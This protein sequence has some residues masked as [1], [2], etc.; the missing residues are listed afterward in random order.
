MKPLFI[1]C[2]AVLLIAVIPGT[3][4]LNADELQPVTSED[5][6]L[7]RPVEFVTDVYPI[8][9]ANCIACHNKSVAEGDLIL[10]NVEAILK[11]G[12]TG[13]AAVPEK[14][15]ES[16]LFLL[17]RRGEEP[18][19]PPLPND[20]QAK[21]LEPKQLGIL[22]QWILEGA[23]K[24]TVAAKTMNWQPISSKLQ[25]VYALDMD[26]A[27][28]FIAAG[29][30]NRVSIYDLARRDHVQ[31]LVDREILLPGMPDGGAGAVAGVTHLDYVHAIAFHPTEPMI[32]TSGYRNVKI[33]KRDSEAAGPNTAIP[34][35]TTS[36]AVSEDGRELVLADPGRGVVVLSSEN[37]TE[38][39]SVKP[40]EHPVTGVGLSESAPGWIL[41][42][43]AD[44]RLHT[45]R[46]S[47]LQVVS[48][49]EPLPSVVTSVSDALAGGRLAVLLSD[50]SVRIVSVAGDTG[51]VEVTAEIRSDAGA[52][53]KICGDKGTL[54][55]VTG[56]RLVQNWNAEN[57]AEVNRFEVPGSIVSLDLN[58][59]DDRAVFTLA[60][61]QSLLWSPKETKQIAALSAEISSQRRLKHL[62]RNK[63]VLDARVGVVLARIDEAEKEVTAQKEAETKAK[64]E[65][66]KLTAPQQ[67]AQTK[68]DAAVA[69]TAAA[70]AAS[71]ESSEDAALK[72]ALAE[73]EKA[74]AAAKDVFTK[75]DSELTL[76]KKSLEF[77]TAAILRAE[78]RVAD[79]RQQHEVV[80][81]EQTTAAEAVEQAKG[82]ASVAAASMAVT[83]VADG[84]FVAS[85]DSEGTLRIW[86]SADGTAVDVL[87]GSQLNGAVTQAIGAGERV[88]L[89][90]ADHRLVARAVFP[91]WSISRSLGSEV[92]GDS[93][94]ADRVLALTFSPDGTLLATGGGEASRSGELMLWS[95]ADGE[96]VHQFADA[97]SDTVYGLDFSAD[98]KQLASASADK[99]VKVFDVAG[100]Q[101]IR[102]YEGHTH[103][104]MDVAWK[105][106]RTILVSA[107]ADNAIKVWN[108]ETGE[109]SRTISTYTR[110]VTSLQF[111][112]LQDIVLS[113]SG[114][115]RVFFHNPGNGSAA[116]E[117][118][119][120]ADYVYRIATNTDGTLVVSGGEDGTVRVWNAADAAEIAKFDAP[121]AQ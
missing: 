22:R 96:L 28:R 23:K 55:T 78:M 79:R 91:G 90:T 5:P 34:E 11:G 42:A 110:Q 62:E 26:G 18:V 43:T 64:A 52:V 119:G 37:D 69:A 70:K 6:A 99:F 3:C 121:Q 45:I 41:A 89:R 73:A 87:P 54:L 75:A 57:G 38:R 46:S 63:A 20:R 114:D 71:E 98:G 100:R 32:A 36:I 15:D 113:S 74:E 1:F 10:E 117:F 105:A 72:T 76:A 4:V 9:E 84:K 93:I 12:S 50:G 59:S 102:S 2:R 61:G 118:K 16:L 7:G 101:Y 53:Q 17:A 13:P 30:A 120:N 14:P 112:G 8:L 81:S 88:L 56:D 107:G 51:V 24:G 35:M 27:G 106:D 66:E 29:R 39:G 116:R 94:F 60:D 109:Q 104:V 21:A 65:V 67:E 19:M 33:W 31:T 97:H 95:V 85:A 68:Y 58:V 77:A 48:G 47:D 80:V 82:P 83:F 25:G 111:V 108:A 92:D 49:S 40:S 86:S 115:K 103:H 44:G